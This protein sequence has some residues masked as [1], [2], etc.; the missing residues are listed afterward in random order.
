MVVTFPEGLPVRL[1][2]NDA[3]DTV[4]GVV[5]VLAFHRA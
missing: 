5:E 4:P 3:E 1:T 2:S